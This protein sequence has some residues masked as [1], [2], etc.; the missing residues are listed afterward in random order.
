MKDI[1]L[2]FKII[3]YGLQFKLMCI[4]SLVFFA[5]GIMFEVMG[6]TSNSTLGALYISLSGL[7]TFQLVF[8]PSVAKIVQVSPYKKKIQTVGSTLI[9]LIFCLTAFTVLVIIRVL[10][11][12]PTF[13]AES[14]STYAK[15]Y[16]VLIYAAII[17]SFLLLYMAFSF[18]MYIAAL[19]ICIC[20]VL[21][22]ML[23]SMNEHF[24]FYENVAS[25]L[26]NGDNP[27]L[28]IAFSYG[29]ILVG[30]LLCYIFSTLLYK[31]EISGLA[32]RNALRQAQAK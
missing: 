8:S 16:S 25:S 32:I 31:R 24:M 4:L 19:I 20:T 9:S 10:R 21:V 30:G 23:F 28:V 2:Y 12:D 13:L 27:A 26:M 3:R 5:L 17:I 11:A 6:S 7:Y 18:K 1:N 22:F 29:I 15:H 14:G